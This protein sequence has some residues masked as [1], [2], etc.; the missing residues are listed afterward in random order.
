LRESGDRLFWISKVLMFRAK[1]L[2][3]QRPAP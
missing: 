3:M 1:L 2:A